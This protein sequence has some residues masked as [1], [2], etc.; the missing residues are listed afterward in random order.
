VVLSHE[1]VREGIRALDND[2]NSGLTVVAANGDLLVIGGGAGRYVAE[3]HPSAAA[4]VYDA[5]GAAGTCQEPL[6]SVLG[7]ISESA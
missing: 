2:R 3:I 5:A 7:T 4:P 1:T 6:L